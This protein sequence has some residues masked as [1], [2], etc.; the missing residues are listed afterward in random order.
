MGVNDTDDLIWELQDQVQRLD[1][2]VSRL[3][4]LNGV[5]P[6]EAGRLPGEAPPEVVKAA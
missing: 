5:D 2:K 1:R 6:E 3:L 4:T